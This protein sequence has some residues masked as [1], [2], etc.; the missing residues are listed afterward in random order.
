MGYHYTSGDFSDQPHAG[1][2]TVFSVVQVCTT[3]QVII[4]NYGVSVLA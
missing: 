3:A 1:F 4:M 2:N